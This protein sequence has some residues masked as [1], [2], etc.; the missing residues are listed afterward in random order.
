MDLFRVETFEADELGHLPDQKTL[1]EKTIAM[2]KNL[3]A[4][5]N[6]PV[7]EPFDGPAILSGRASAVFFHEV[8]VGGTA[9]AWR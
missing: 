4:L 9:A 2:A 5:R 8:L 3:E 7:T 1:T 6:A